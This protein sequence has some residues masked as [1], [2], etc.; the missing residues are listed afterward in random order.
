MISTRDKMSATTKNRVNTKASI[1]FCVLLE[2]MSTRYALLRAYIIDVSA[3]EAINTEDTALNVN[4]PVL[5]VSIA[6]LRYSNTRSK[7]FGGK[8]L[9]STVESST[10]SIESKPII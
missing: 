9:E 1:R 4:I 10:V 7:M 6:Y 8:N 5:V 3:F 2:C